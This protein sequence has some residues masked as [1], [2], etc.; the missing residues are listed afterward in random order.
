MYIS[1]QP[2]LRSAFAL[3]WAVLAAVSC[4]GGRPDINASSESV[5]G[6]AGA[7]NGGTTTTTTTHITGGSAGAFVVVIGKGGGVGTAGTTGSPSKPVVCG[8]G[9]RGQDEACDDGNTTGGDG[10]SADCKVVEEGFACPEPGKACVPS[11]VC[12]DKK[13]SGTENCD[14]GNTTDGDGCSSS[15]RTDPGWSCPFLG[16][17]CVAERCG[18]GI[19]AGTETCD[20]GNATSGDG[21]SSICSVESPGPTDRN[22]WTCPDVGQPCVRT[23]CG[24]ATPEGTEQCDDGNNDSGDG[25]SPACRKEPS[26]PPEGGAC[27]SVCGDGM[28]LPTDTDQECD[29]GNSTNGDGCSSDC[30]VELGYE[31]KPTPV[32]PSGALVLPVVYRDFK[33]PTTFGGV[34]NIAA[35]EHPDFEHAP[36]QQETGIV[37]AKLGQNGKP[38]HSPN[39][40]VTTTNNDTATTPDWFS[41][42]YKDAVADLPTPGSPRYNY[43]FVDWLTLTETAANSGT[44]RYS[45]TSFFPL[46][47]RT[48]SWGNTSGQS[49]NFNFTSEVR[50]WFQYSGNELL[51][52]TGD[53]DV[54][55]FVNKQLAV[56]LGGIHGA[57][58]GSVRLHATAGTGSVCEDAA[59][60]CTNPRTVNLGLVI[61]NVY[62]MVVFQAER[63]VT[64]SNYT[65]TISSFNATRSSCNSVC[66]DGIVTPDEACDLG[67][68]NNAGEYGTCTPDCKLPPYCGDAVVNGPEECDDG[69]NLSAYGYNGTP[70]CAPGC[71]WTHFCGDGNLDGLFGEQCDDHNRVSGD[72]CE[73]NCTHRVGCGNGILEPG[74]QCDD[75]NTR[76]GDGCSEFCTIV[77]ILF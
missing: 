35:G 10:C 66:G 2:S 65:L 22:A 55:V 44:F 27:K 77:N 16:I 12:G 53:D 41:L 9:E 75:G 47:G 25:C 52:F 49:H 72:G 17:R 8:D 18:D 23:A 5:V 29:D 21:C 60:G 73:A 67:T 57:I 64:Q 3:L 11:Q 15:C 51:S 39:N 74:E 26:C 30:K 59:P 45:N 42:W 13:I 1:N 68:A 54:W 62:E 31:C 48:P 24:D 50:Y 28:I 58:N 20:D 37:Q 19:L 14:D 46:D 33:G 34:A 4:N 32:R 69:L 36:V 7:G 6:T 43:T 76:S 38:V 61:G 70:A 40:M 63:H 56:D 71:V